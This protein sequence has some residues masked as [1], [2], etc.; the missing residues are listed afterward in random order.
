MKRLLPML[1][2]IATPAVAQGPGTNIGLAQYPAPACQKPQ[3]VDATAKPK[4]PPENASETQAIGYNRQ[5]DAYNAAMR[6]H[7]EQAAAFTTCI[8]AYIANGNAD[9]QRIRAA[10]DAAVASANAP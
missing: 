8:N 2:L 4:P 10:L 1:L 9:M 5:V 7:N 6:A 3:A